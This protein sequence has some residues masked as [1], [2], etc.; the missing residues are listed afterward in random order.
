MPILPPLNITLSSEKFEIIVFK[1][2]TRRVVDLPY[3]LKTNKIRG[4]IVTGYNVNKFFEFRK[5]RREALN[6]K[7]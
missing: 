2:K 1:I 4:T 6:V 5:F 3:F 7:T